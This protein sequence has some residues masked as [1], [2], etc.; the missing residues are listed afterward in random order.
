MS[1]A[2]VEQL[3]NARILVTGVTGWVGGPIATSLAAAGNE[4]YGAARFADPAAREPFDAAGVQTVSV[5]LA[6][7][8]FDELPADLDLV[9]HFAVSKSRR[10]DAAFATNAEGSANLIEAVSGRSDRLRAFLHCSST[11]VYQPQGHEPLAETAALGDSHRLMPGM[12]TYSISKIA[13]E[14]LVQHTCKRLGVP[15]V[16][17]RLSVPY[18]DTYGWMLFHLAMMERGLPVPVH[19]DAPSSYSPIHTDDIVRSLPYL[20]SLASVPAEVVNWGGDEVVS[21]EEWCAELGRLTG[22][23]PEF[24]HTEATIPAIVP[25]LT[26]LR[27]TGFRPQVGWRDGLRRLVANSR[28]ELLRA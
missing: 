14:V 20:L 22:L 12:A 4:V 10:F 3:S 9:L 17:G 8:R 13:A 21:V 15:T 18:G 2:D 16:I 6:G 27:A 28:P 26:K 7:G 25:E 19:P 24:E 5:D 11:G 23:M 1:A